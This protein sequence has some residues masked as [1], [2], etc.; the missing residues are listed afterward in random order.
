MILF[1]SED[2]AISAKNYANNSENKK[3]HFGIPIRIVQNVFAV[4]N[5]GRWG[6]RTLDLCRVKAAL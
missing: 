6:T 1:K 5:G 3:R 2:L 4:S